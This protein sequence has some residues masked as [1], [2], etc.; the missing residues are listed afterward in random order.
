MLTDWKGKEKSGFL[1]TDNMII[2]IE[3]IKILQKSKVNRVTW[4]KVN[5]QKSILC[6]YISKKQLEV[7][8][9]GITLLKIL[10]YIE[11]IKY[12]GINLTKYMQAA[13]TENHSIKIPKQMTRNT[14][15]IN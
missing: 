6:L 2:Y 10:S 5:A 4:Y 15:I 11:N 13:Y 3:I 7:K 12:L 1:F 9:K 8:S 14:M